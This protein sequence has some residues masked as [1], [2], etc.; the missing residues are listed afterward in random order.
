MSIFN[1]E[2]AIEE[3]KGVLKNGDTLYT[4]VQH[5]SGSGMTRDI[6]V[7][8]ISDNRPLNFNYWVAKALGYR[9]KNNGIRISGCGMDMGFALI[10]N[11]SRTLDIDLKQEWI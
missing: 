3:L 9:M 6:K 1:K 7:I 11:L 10:Y 8:K 2:D 4:N 5:V